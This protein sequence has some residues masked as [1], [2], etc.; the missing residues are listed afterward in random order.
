ML[1][2]KQT[3]TKQ[4]KDWK[5]HIFFFP[6]AV[7]VQ[8]QL[9]HATSGL[10]R[11]LSRI[12][13]N[14]AMKA[15]SSER[16][17]FQHF[18]HRWRPRGPNVQKSTSPWGHLRVVELLDDDG[19]VRVVPGSSW[20]I[21]VGPVVPRPGACFIWWRAL[22]P[23]Q[24]ARVSKGGPR[25]T[26]NQPDRTR[27]P[28]EGN[29]RVLLRNS[30]H[31]RN[32]GDA[33]DQG[34]CYKNQHWPVLTDSIRGASIGVRWCQNSTSATGPFSSTNRPDSTYRSH[35]KV[36]P[37]P[38]E[39]IRFHLAV[40]VFDLLLYPL[41]RLPQDGHVPH[42]T[43]TD[44]R[45]HQSRKAAARRLLV[46]VDQLHAFAPGIVLE[47]LVLRFPRAAAKKCDA[48]NGTFRTGKCQDLTGSKATQHATTKRKVNRKHLYQATYASVKPVAKG[49]SFH[50][51]SLSS[52]VSA[53]NRASKETKEGALPPAASEVD[54]VMV[55]EGEFPEVGADDDS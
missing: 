47:V 4:T 44:R 45:T 39:P 17:P 11:N 7:P 23:W 16:E 8:G 12:I 20:A 14:N 1:N 43:S 51:F 50:R 5:E 6:I 48:N 15:D 25:E 32:K 3:N 29:E 37:W 9:E 55:A 31:Q 46:A 10:A 35:D 40:L 27:Q 13:S 2:I 52:L 33:K 42:S 19:R 36:Q 34:V 21:T 53:S 26:Q 54:A 28:D 38:S 22:A 49:P 18:R 30:C 24:D 41:R